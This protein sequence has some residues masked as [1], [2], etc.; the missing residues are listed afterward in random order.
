MFSHRRSWGARG[1]DGAAGRR[2]VVWLCE[3]LS[4]LWVVLCGFAGVS[5]AT[6]RLF[7]DGEGSLHYQCSLPGLL[8]RSSRGTSMSLERSCDPLSRTPNLHHGGIRLKYAHLLYLRKYIHSS[9]RV[10][11]IC[12]EVFCSLKT[13]L[14]DVEGCHNS[15]GQAPEPLAGRCGQPT[16]LVDP[17]PSKLC[18]AC[19]LPFIS[20]PWYR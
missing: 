6:V 7:K 2:A 4:A 16:Q 12:S 9:F 10:C 17:T 5:C 11:L 15:R 19:S 1:R 14:M 13:C 20:F 3:Q 18:I 8:C